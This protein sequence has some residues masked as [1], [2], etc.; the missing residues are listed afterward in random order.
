[1]DQAADQALVFGRRGRRR[2]RQLLQVQFQRRFGGGS[3]G[4]FFAMMEIGGAGDE[5]RRFGA[6]DVDVPDRNAEFG[7]NLHDVSRAARSAGRLSVP[8]RDQKVAIAHDEAP[9]FE[10]GG[11]RP[12]QAVRAI[13]LQLSAPCKSARNSGAVCGKSS[14]YSGCGKGSGAW[15]RAA[16]FRASSATRRSAPSASGE[17]RRRRNGARHRAPCCS[18]APFPRRA[19][20]VRPS[21]ARK[22]L[23]LLAQDFGGRGRQSMAPET[24]MRNASG[25]RGTIGTIEVMRSSLN[26]RTI[27]PRT[28]AAYSATGVA[29]LAST[30]A[31]PFRF[32]N[33]F[34]AG[35]SRAARGR[36]P[37]RKSAHGPARPHPPS[38]C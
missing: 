33:P 8:D 3:G 36:W 18:R 16:K 29:R 11:F 9:D 27:P 15:S 23:H 31:A 30:G 20:P 5:S 13:Q 17:T 4:G 37:V 19:A 14:S 32:S 25:G 10:I 7:G 12:R 34:A 6:V 22:F 1:M 28:G 24:P 38:I 26:A 2:R 21:P 35:R